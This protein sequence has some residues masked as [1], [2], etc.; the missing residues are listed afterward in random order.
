MLRCNFFSSTIELNKAKNYQLSV[1]STN[2]N[3]HKIPF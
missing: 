1:R 3:K 2:W